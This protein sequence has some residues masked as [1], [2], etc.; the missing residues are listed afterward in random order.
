MNATLNTPALPIRSSRD[1][2]LR[3]LGGQPVDRPP[4][5]FMRQ[6]GRHLPG[7]RALRQTHSFL[8]ICRRE[9]VNTPASAEPVQ[10]YGIDAAIVFNDI[11][12]PLMD[13]GMGLDFLPAPK[14]DRLVASTAD[15]ASL[16]APVYNQS[17]DVARCLRALR[18]SIGNDT[19]MLGFVGAPFTVAS[20]AIGGV[21]ASR[22]PLESLVAQR[23]DVFHA[24]QERLVGV[25]TDYAAVQ[26]QAGADVIQVFESLADQLSEEKF[27][28][29]GLPFLRDLVDSI[30]RRVPGTPLIVFGRGLWP[31][32]PEL[33]ATGA[34]LSLDHG[35]PLSQARRTLRSLGRNNALQGNLDPEV[36]M[37]PPEQA[38]AAARALLGEWRDITSRPDELEMF[39]PTGWVF[40]LGHGVPA[41]ADPR[42]V[43]AVV[44][45]VK[46]H[47][48]RAASSQKEAVS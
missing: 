36:L 25:L 33:S 17:T 34:A 14:F 21:G 28:A 29:V 4:M 46:Q 38:A 20:F 42:T 24:F 18:R 6:A 39:G 13:M 31:Y 43:Q 8:D 30:A 16:R 41:D 22:S 3:T 47:R 5:W 35:N 12:I 23:P 15:V 2:M 7:Y 1:R 44:D 26:V 45:A 19:A 32:I 40:N 27:R 9:D 48:F 37:L 10:R 11:L